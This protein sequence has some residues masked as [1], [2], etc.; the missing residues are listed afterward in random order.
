M[1]VLSVDVV[2]N[3][4]QIGANLQSAR[5]GKGSFVD[6]FYRT[7]DGSLLAA[8]RGGAIM[9]G[10]RI[11]K[12][13]DKNVYLMELSDVQSLLMKAPRPV[14][15]KFQRSLQKITVDEFVHNT[16][17]CDWVTLYLET[18]C[19]KEDAV[20]I[21][22]K[23]NVLRVAEAIAS[24]ASSST[25]GPSS[26]AA[27]A[28]DDDPRDLCADLR[29]TSS[30]TGRTLKDCCLQCI[31][32]CLEHYPS[33]SATQRIRCLSVSVSD[34]ALLEP[35]VLFAAVRAVR[36][37]LLADLKQSML[38]KFQSCNTARRMTGWFAG[39]AA[40]FHRFS[41]GALLADAD[42]GG[43]GEGEGVLAASLYLFLRR[44]GQ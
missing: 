41:L 36:D 12:V 9:I 33:S 23:M 24:V 6:S 13:N 37:L 44:I 7:H 19:N 28:A 15:L 27:A 25:C 5:G 34:G 35:P 31:I 8:E 21:T 20:L 29:F 38:V 14:R 42:A 22:Q 18:Y 26:V 3:D 30:S 2:I 40:R 11:F 16:F 1:S 32:F 10:D 39:S 17:L 43:E 4:D